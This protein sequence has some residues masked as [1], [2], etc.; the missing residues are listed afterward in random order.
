MP[1]IEVASSEEYIQLID[2][3]GDQVVVVDFF[4]TW[5]GPCKMIAPRY[6]E[7][8][9]EFSE[10]TFLKVDVDK[11]K[12]RRAL[13][14]VPVGKTAGCRSRPSV[15]QW[16]E[17]GAAVFGRRS[18]TLVLNSITDSAVTGCCC[19]CRGFS[20]AYVSIVQE[21]LEGGRVERS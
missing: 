8:S 16:Q 4:A 5:C 2:D 21:W 15:Q 9:E 11:V 19:C 17:G 12:V 1:V 3:G 20:D 10:A 14:D 6:E 7:L 18:T 13:C